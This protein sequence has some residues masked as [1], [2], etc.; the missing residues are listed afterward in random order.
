MA[1]DAVIIVKA[2]KKALRDFEYFAKR[3]FYIRSKDGKVKPLVL[4]KEQKIIVDRIKKQQRAGKP[5]RIVILKARQVGVSTV[6]EAYILWR[7]LRDS[8]INALE[9]AHEKESARY[10]LSISR[11]AVKRM[12]DWFRAVCGVKEEYFTKYEIAFEHNGSSL[13]ISSADSDEPGRSRTLHLLHLSE[14]AFYRNA[15]ELL[16]ALF[17]AVPKTPNT[18]VFVES[19]GVAPAGFFYDLYTQAKNGKNDYEAIFFSWYMHEEYRMPVPEGVEVEVPPGLE[20]LDKEQLYWRQWVIEN[21]YLGDESKFTQEYP[22][23]EEE[24]WLRETANVF[25]PRMVNARIKEV[26]KL[27][28]IEGYLVR[29]TAES[30]IEFIAGVG[31]KLHIYKKPEPNRMYVIGADVG[32]GVVVNREGDY[33]SAD[34]IDIVTG[35]QVAHYHVLLEPGQFAQELILLGTFYNNALVAVEVTGGHGLSVVTTMRDNNYTALYRRKVYD[36]ISQSWVDKLGWNTTKATKNMII[37]GLRADFRDGNMIVNEKA[38]L[39]EMLTFIKL[40]DKSDQIGAAPGAKDDR[41]ISVAIAAQVRREAVPTAVSTSQQ[42]KTEQPAV[43]EPQQN[44]WRRRKGNYKFAHPE[45]GAF[46]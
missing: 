22:A 7:L 40:S 45:L 25:S 30:P 2:T 18:A 41:V 5:V 15:D 39:K 14:A 23:T 6:I 36:K 28:Y 24:A 13:S 43:Q 1:N 46:W 21:D 38:T 3:C 11:F 19:T 9:L 31:E 33:S 26:E 35:E 16:K 4:N 17:A 29:R 42:N 27:E 44:P 20:H 34:V 37:N 32:S 12:P 10:I 8:N